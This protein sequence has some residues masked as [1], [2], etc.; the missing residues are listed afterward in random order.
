MLPQQRLSP[1]EAVDR[2]LCPQLPTDD[3]L[4]SGAVQTQPCGGANGAFLFD[5]GAHVDAGAFRVDAIA[6]NLLDQQ[7]G[8]RD[9]P[10]GFGGTSFR[11]LLTLG[12]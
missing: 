2:A 5:L 10:I 8:L 1:V 9:E 11:A 4:A 12:L 6:E 3:Q 7:G